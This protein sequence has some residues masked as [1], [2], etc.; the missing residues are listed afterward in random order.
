MQVYLTEGLNTWKL[1]KQGTGGSVNAS[2]PSDAVE[3]LI[4][5]K[6]SNSAFVDRI[7]SVVLS[8]QLEYFLHGFYQ[9]SSNAFGAYFYASKTEVSAISVTEN[10][11]SKT[12]NSQY[13]IYYRID[14]L[15]F[16][17]SYF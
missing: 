11:Q 12:S 9:T 2:I 14:I 7:P 8:D 6:F 10:G 3:L 4:K 17:L 1:L 13:F 16:L 15:S 5:I